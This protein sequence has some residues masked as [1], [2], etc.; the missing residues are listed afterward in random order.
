M[1]W[2]RTKNVIV[3]ISQLTWWE[4]RQHMLCMRKQSTVISASGC[5]HPKV[6]LNLEKSNI[7][8]IGF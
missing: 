4:S 5:L 7:N 1:L 3:F 6:D 2:R 8:D